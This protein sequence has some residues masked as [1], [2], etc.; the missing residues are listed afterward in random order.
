MPRVP[1][2][3]GQTVMPQA[4]PQ[5]FQRIQASPAAFGA[6]IGE[7]LAQGGARVANATD[8]LAG[9][10]I[11]MRR[12]DDALKVE[13]AFAGW[14]DRERAFL[15]DPERGVYTRRGSNAVTAYDEASKWWDESAKTTIEG[16]ENPNQQRLM[17]SMLARRRDAALDGVA[18]HVA[19]E[20]QTAMGETWTARLRGIE[21]DAA[22]AF[23]D[24]GKVNALLEEAD[25]GTIFWGRRQGLSEDGIALSR[26]A[27]RS[28]IRSSV[29]ERMALSDPIAAKA[30]YDQHKD[31]IDGT[32]QVK[33][34]RALKSSVEQ[35]VALNNAERVLPPRG[36]PV[37]MGDMR[38]RVWAI[39]G[40]AA[41]NPAPGQTARGG[42][43]TDGTWREYSTRLGLTG[44]QRGTR[45]AFDRVWDAYQQDATRRIGRNLSPG[46][47]YAAW[48]LGIGGAQAFLAADRNADAREVYGRAA[49]EGIAD[50]AFSV[51]GNMM[52]PGMTVGQVL[53]G[54]MAKA[55]SG[56]AR[57]S[58]ARVQGTLAQRVDEL[59]RNMEGESPEVIQRAETL[60]RSQF[61]QRHADEEDRYRGILRSVRDTVYRDKNFNTL[62]P[63]QLAFLDDN[64]VEKDALEKYVRQD[65]R[66]FTDQATYARISMMDPDEFDSVDLMDPQYRTNL[67]ETDWKRFVDQQRALRNSTDRQAASA[68]RAGQRN[69]TQIVSTALREAGIDPT[70]ADT[71]KTGAERVASFNRAFDDRLAAW[72]AENRGKRPTPQDLQRIADALLISGRIEG[73]GLWGLG[74]TSRRAFEVRDQNERDKFRVSDLSDPVQRARVSRATGIPPDDIKEVLETLALEKAELTLESIARFG[75]LLRERRERLAQ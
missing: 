53:D 66:M 7:A 5:P 39:E 45:E 36:Q 52:R 65:G 43:I 42:G 9:R 28:S 35:R 68:E 32:T 20:R 57:P 6:G 71:N 25:S 67:S 2:Y 26:R 8:R 60:L 47:Q 46:E 69:R 4:V 74:Q 55:G 37:A 1:A 3:P 24:E 54:I 21:Q 33:I 40:G 59:R 11:E 41:R 13:Q 64:P 48:F 75:R 14:S 51:N 16:L 62:T 38:D 10:A 70:P 31:E 30:Y 34:E 27:A 56:T 29:V 12:E 61:N 63:D 50:Q 73:T 23:N 22:A 15:H 72:Q 49:G 44:E 18:R 19:R 17:Q 58:E